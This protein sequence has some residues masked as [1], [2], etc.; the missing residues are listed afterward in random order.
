MIKDMQAYLKARVIINSSG[1]WIWQKHRNR[2]G[3]G[4]MLS[5]LAHRVSYQAFNGPIPKG[6]YVCHK[7]NVTACINPEHLYAG[8]AWDNSQDAV[9]AGV[10]G[11]KGERHPK[12]ILTNEDVRQMRQLHKD[13]ETIISLAERF[14]V[15]YPTVWQIIRLKNWTHVT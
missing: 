8:T 3:Y 7:C 4:T 5:T 14:K 6:F 2:T 15:K 9:R 1:C 10:L 12:A 13:G 11:S